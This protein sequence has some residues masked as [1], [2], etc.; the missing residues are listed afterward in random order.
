MSMGL[1]PKV[2][3]VHRGDADL[4]YQVFGDGATNLLYLPMASH[5]EQIWQFPIVARQIERLATMSRIV[6][7]DLR[8]FGM[9]D[10][11]P[12]GGYPIEELA[13]DALAVM[14]AA[15]FDR[16]VLYG[17][18]MNGAIAIWLAVHCVDRVDGLILNDTSAC[19]RAGP[20]YDI[21][22]SQTEFDDRRGVFQSLWGTGVTIHFLAPSLAD[23]ERLVEEWAR[24]ERMIATPN[25]I[26]TAFDVVGALDV[27]DLLPEVSTRALV[28]HA[29]ESG[30]IPV[31]HGRYLAEHIPAARYVEVNS[32][33]ALELT[34]TGILGDLAEF[35]TGSRAAAHIERS[36]QVVLF[37]DIAESTERA[38][39]IGD[40]A[41]R[42]LLSQFRS[43]VRAV[44]DRYD[45]REVNT[46]GDDFFAVVSSPSVAIEIAR[47]VRTEAATLDL[48][49]RSG[50]HLGEVEQQGDDFAGLAVHIGAR[51]AALAAPGEI[52]VSQTV[53]D[54][55]VGSGI[56]WTSRGAHHLKG[57]PDEWRT[58]AV[59]N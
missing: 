8:G 14:D 4:A 48:E 29:A 41:W 11:L 16:A 5:L 1:A 49:V 50:L 46:R 21:G 37:T 54:A 17:D 55:L 53:R 36:L 23:D 45:A 27:R 22:F 32:D 3:F 34:T 42:D 56:E 2:Q 19:Y 44:L 58:Y 39:A 33:P 59:T 13:A 30:L 25:A 40:H 57:V 47:A 26:L 51:V 10:P 38:T 52:L 43:D 7:Y 6:M 24:Y 9:S 18:H 28:I 12:A 35:L 15:E 31:S 20:G